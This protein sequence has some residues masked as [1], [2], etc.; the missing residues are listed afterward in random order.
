[1]SNSRLKDV[2][3]GK[4]VFAS[5][6]W[7]NAARVILERLVAEHGEQ[8]RTFSLCERFNEAPREISPRGVVAWH[9]RVDG[10][11][12][13]V[14]SGEIDDADV[15]ITVDYAAVLPG[16]RRVYTPEQLAE[17]PPI[18]TTSGDLSKAPS[19]LLELHNRLALITA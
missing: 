13:S 12:A 8:G 9:F 2:N 18:G 15:T 17:R 16:A 19:Y 4:V 5:G 7:V 11:S 6:P 3:E 14:G 1:M 10:K